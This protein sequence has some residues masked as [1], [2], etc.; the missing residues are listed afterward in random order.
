MYGK[1]HPD[2]CYYDPSLLCLENYFP[3]CIALPHAQKCCT[4]CRQ[5]HSDS[6]VPCGQFSCSSYM[7]YHLCSQQQNALACSNCCTTSHLQVK[8]QD[9][10]NLWH[11]VQTCHM[12]GRCPHSDSC[13]LHAQVPDSSST[14]VVWC[15]QKQH[16]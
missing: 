3:L 9:L 4:S 14:A 10:G 1:S 11:D 2:N 6:H 7:L 16:A 8:A 12:R 5:A 15:T 13:L